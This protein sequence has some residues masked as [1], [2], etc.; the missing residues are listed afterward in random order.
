[1]AA[2]FDA[3][4]A[5][6][7]TAFDDLADDLGVPV[8]VVSLLSGT[9]RV[10][11]DIAERARRLLDSFDSAGDGGPGGGHPGG[12]GHPDAEEVNERET[13]VAVF[14]VRHVDVAWPTALPDGGRHGWG[15]PASALLGETLPGMA[16]RLANALHRPGGHTLVLGTEELMYTPMRIADA[17][18]GV[19]GGQG[20]RVAYQS[21][22]RSPVHPVDVPGY[23]IRTA[24]TF[25]AP[26]DPARASHLYNVRYN[27]RPGS[28]DEIVVFID[29]A[30]AGAGSGTGSPGG[31]DPAGLADALRRCAPVTIATIPS[32]IPA[33]AR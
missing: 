16:A 11:P 33:A 13:G 4:P 17:L 22:T 9:V 12:D 24:L 30:A 21:T 3:R 32:Y 5:T 18:D 31:A 29:D 7:R 2:L 10:P 28:Y 6:A 14:P 19:V 25:P 1:V 23:A 26:D 8:D 27:V 20:G 15:P